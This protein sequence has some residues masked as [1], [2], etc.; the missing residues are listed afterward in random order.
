MRPPAREVD[1][2]LIDRSGVPPGLRIKGR[3]PRLDYGTTFAD[4]YAATPVLPAATALAR[5][6]D[7]MTRF[8]G[9]LPFDGGRHPVP[10]LTS[11]LFQPVAGASTAQGTILCSPK[12]PL[13]QIARAPAEKISHTLGWVDSNVKLRVEDICA[14]NAFADPVARAAATTALIGFALVLK[15]DGHAFARSLTFNESAFTQERIV[16]ALFG[17]YADALSLIH[18]LRA[19]RLNRAAY[20]ISLDWK[21]RGLADLLRIAVASGGAIAGLI[22]DGEVLVTGSRADLEGQFA[23]ALDT[24]LTE[25]S[26]TADPAFADFAERL[27]AQ[28]CRLAW[29]FDDNGETMF[30]L[31]FLEKVLRETATQLVLVANA[32]AVSENIT[33]TQLRRQLDAGAFPSLRAALATGRA[34]L[35]EERQLMPGLEPVWLRAATRSALSRVGPVL[36][37]GANLYETFQLPDLDAYYA[38]VVLGVNS[39]RLTGRDTYTPVLLHSPKGH[40]YH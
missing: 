40:R 7:E 2:L 14:V 16:D 23:R 3:A 18:D 30:D 22:R 27:T 35:V 11:W 9:R 17:P 28:R 10:H 34:S 19:D 12:S 20:A 33:T 31:L 39:V 8:R 1:P 25:R 15:S 24:Y 26:H 36:C 6:R 4:V 21:D 37:K 29:I 32:T 13:M 5:L 38:F